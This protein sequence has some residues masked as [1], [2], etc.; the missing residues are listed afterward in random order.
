MPN[1][2]KMTCCKEKSQRSILKRLQC[3]SQST[4]TKNEK[5]TGTFG[6]GLHELCAILAVPNTQHTQRQGILRDL[7]SPLLG[8]LAILADLIS[9]DALESH[10]ETWLPAVQHAAHMTAISEVGVSPEPLSPEPW[11][12]NNHVPCR[13]HMPCARALIAC[14]SGAL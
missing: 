9:N 10:F 2:A 14:A 1:Q 13:Q 4:K 7:G 5:G 8:S 3:C 12:H 11:R 6:I